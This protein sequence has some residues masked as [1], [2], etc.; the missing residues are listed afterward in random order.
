MPSKVTIEDANE[1]V[2]SRWS[3]EN[4]LWVDGFS[5]MKNGRRSNDYIRYFSCQDAGSFLLSVK[6][7]LRPLG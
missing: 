6:R 7:K 4:H 5:G 1:I 2:H 3:T